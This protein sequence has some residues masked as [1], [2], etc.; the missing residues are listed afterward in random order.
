MGD[1]FWN[2][3]WVKKYKSI[4][5]IC[6]CVK[7]VM[8][9][10]TEFYLSNAVQSLAWSGS[11]KSRI[12]LIATGSDRIRMWGRKSPIPS[13]LSANPVSF[14]P[15]FCN[16]LCEL[17]YFTSYTVKKPD[18]TNT[19][20][21]SRIDP[22]LHFSCVH[23]WSHI[24]YSCFSNKWSR[25]LYSF[26]QIIVKNNMTREPAILKLKIFLICAFFLLDTGNFVSVP[27]RYR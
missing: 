6:C 11:G 2:G 23:N 16:N 7:A 22:H 26:L 14:L 9:I 4:H 15:I 13:K 8:Q 24:V 3:A 5:S 12:E 21:A 10:L 18:S 25:D 1:L 17:S 20:L 27:Y 19:G